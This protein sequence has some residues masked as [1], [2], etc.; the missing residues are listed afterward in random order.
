ME[1]SSVLDS[2]NNS[3]LSNEGKPK[4]KLNK[5]N[6]DNMLFN[7]YFYYCC[8]SLFYYQLSIFKNGRKVY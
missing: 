1:N 2:N 7:H 4:G 3:S 6:S 8:S 5:K